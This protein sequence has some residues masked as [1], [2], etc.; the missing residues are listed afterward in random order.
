L[1]SPATRISTAAWPATFSART[2]VNTVI[3]LL[4]RRKHH[5]HGM[6]VLEWDRNE[7]RVV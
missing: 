1:L 6:L 7:A 3:G 5:P 4:S 2:V